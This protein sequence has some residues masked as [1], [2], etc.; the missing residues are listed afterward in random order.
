MEID[1]RNTITK[2]NKM[3]NKIAV[4]L[5]NI[6]AH[7]NTLRDEIVQLEEDNEK[8]NNCL[9]YTSPSPRD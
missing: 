4:E 2:E 8:L 3:S 9:L 5:N 7:I 6:V 1:K